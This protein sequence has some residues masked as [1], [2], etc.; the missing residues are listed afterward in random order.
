MYGDIAAWPNRLLALPEAAE[1]SMSRARLLTVAAQAA[2]RADA[3][4]ALLL[5]EESVV[6][7]RTTGDRPCLERTLASLAFMLIRR[8]PVAARPFAEEALALAREQGDVYRESLRLL[9]LSRIAAAQ[10]D[11]EAARTYQEQ[12]V[13]CADRLADERWRGFANHQRGRLAQLNGDLTSARH[14]WQESVSRFEALG[15]DNG[16]RINTSQLLADVLQLQG[17]TREAAELLR[18][19]LLSS[20][21][22]GSYVFAL[23]GIEVA[24]CIAAALHL[25][26]RAARLLAAAQALRVRLLESERIGPDPGLEAAIDRARAALGDDRLAA[27]WAQ[28]EPLSRNEAIELA[29]ETLDSARSAG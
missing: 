14:Y 20:Q 29:L 26:E 23:D 8:D 27:A 7:S 4:R 11:A 6:I 13:A 28:G 16:N 10:G 5:L 18:E 15:I 17:A 2:V 3:A 21:K 9:Y 24:G 19:A 25:P 12:A 22:L 1:P